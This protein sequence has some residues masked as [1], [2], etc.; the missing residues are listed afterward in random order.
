MRKDVGRGRER[1]KGE[2]ISVHDSEIMGETR[3]VLP[4]YPP[5]FA[6]QCSY[7]V[8]IVPEAGS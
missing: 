2:G 4:S 5:N 3:D 6:R 7:I 8:V 1:D